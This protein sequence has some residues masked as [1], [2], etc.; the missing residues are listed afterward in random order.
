MYIVVLITDSIFDGCQK[1]APFEVLSEG[2][3]EELTE[4]PLEIVDD[5][6][7]QGDNI[8][9]PIRWVAG[10]HVVRSITRK[11]VVPANL[12]ARVRLISDA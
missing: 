2:A 9:F 3:V 11:A 5:V 8:L 6:E 12:D 4:Q 1:K 10:R 7:R